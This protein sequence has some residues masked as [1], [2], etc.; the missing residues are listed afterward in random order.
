MKPS[1]Q[2]CVSQ[3]GQLIWHWYR[4]MCC[5]AKTIE[6][7]AFFSPSPDHMPLPSTWNRLLSDNGIW[8]VLCTL[9]IHTTVGTIDPDVCSNVDNQNI[10]PPSVTAASSAA[11]VSTSNINKVEPC[12]WCGHRRDS[13]GENAKLTDGRRERH[14]LKRDSMFPC[15]SPTKRWQNKAISFYLNPSFLRRD[16]RA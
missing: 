14:P 11:N 16:C 7:N 2:W 12:G 6:F 9:H 4:E 13:P 8:A 1:A 5:P 10:F 3:M 15:Y